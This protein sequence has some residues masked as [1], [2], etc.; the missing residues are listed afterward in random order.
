MTPTDMIEHT[1]YTQI[2]KHSIYTHT[3]ILLYSIYIVISTYLLIHYTP[4][5]LVNIVDLGVCEFDLNGGVQTLSAGIQIQS[6]IHTLRLG[7]SQPVW[8]ICPLCLLP[9]WPCRCHRRPVPQ[10]ILHPRNKY[11]RIFGTPP[12]YSVPHTIY[13]RIYGT[14]RIFST[15]L[16]FM[17]FY[18]SG[19]TNLIL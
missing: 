5:F 11:P 2:H 7:H 3:I 13:P 15:P 16:L 9:P 19:S 14:P 12:G 4:H 17:V 8:L 6:M 1:L 18:F 10:D